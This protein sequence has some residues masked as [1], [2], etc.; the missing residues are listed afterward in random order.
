MNKNFMKL[1][2]FIIVL[3]VL[4]GVTKITI[5][6]FTL[7]PGEISY[8]LKCDKQN[9]CQKLVSEQR[10]EPIEKSVN[11]L[12]NKIER[13]AGFLGPLSQFVRYNFVVNNNFA[14]FREVTSPPS[15]EELLNKQL[16]I[17]CSLDGKDVT[18]NEGLG[19]LFGPSSS[20]AD[21]TGMVKGIGLKLAKSCKVDLPARIYGGES[22][23]LGKDGILSFGI[24]ERYGF[25]FRIDRVSKILIFIFWALTLTGLLPLSREFVRFLSRGRKYFMD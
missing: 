15:Y 24:V 11:R 12:T 23:V 14:I 17:L 18:L 2:R 10:I 22:F 13:V 21:L 16:T 3:I 19:L 4:L 6:F 7:N 1:T 5:I 25:Q 9:N 8:N 20:L